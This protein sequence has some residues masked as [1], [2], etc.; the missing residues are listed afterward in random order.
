MTAINV[1]D[2][3]RLDVERDLATGELVN[4]IQNPSGDLG[5]WGWIT[6][7]ASTAMSGGTELAYAGVASVANWFTS[8]LSPVTA[9]N[10]VAAS[11]TNPFHTNSGLARAQLVWYDSTG[12][13]VSSGTQAP[14]RPPRARTPS[15]RRWSLPASLRWRSGSTCTARRA[16]SRRPARRSRCG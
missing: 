5:G 9:G 3:V 13:V 6:P 7:V 14:T 4:L 2:R 11:W 8:E 15:A 10:Y 16:A 12:A 1:L